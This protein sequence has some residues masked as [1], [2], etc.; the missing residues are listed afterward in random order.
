MSFPMESLFLLDFKL[1][2][3]PANAM[4]CLE[5]EF[6]NNRGNCTPCKQC[7]PGLELSQECGFGSGG[8][9]HCVSCS[10]CF[11]KD[12][13]GHQSC[14]R[15]QSCKL[16]SRLQISNCTAQRNAV[17]GECL[18]GFYSKA[19]IGG[20]QDVQCIPCTGQTPPSELQCS[21]RV[22]IMKVSGSAAPP[23]DTAAAA[24]VCSALVTVAIALMILSFLYCRC[25][26]FG[27]CVQ[28]FLR[29]CSAD[30]SER[31][32]AVATD[33]PRET[34]MQNAA[35]ELSPVVQE[36]VEPIGQ[37]VD[38]NPASLR[39]CMEACT[40][41]GN[42]AKTVEPKPQCVSSLSETQ[43]LI[44]DST[45]STC[46]SWSSSSSRNSAESSLGQPQE[47]TSL[48][49]YCALEQ[50]GR[51][52][53][54]PV[55]CTE[56]DFQ[57]CAARSKE[58]RIGDTAE[59]AQPEALSGDSLMEKEIRISPVNI[60]QTTTSC[61]RVK[62]ETL[63]YGCASACHVPQNCT[64]M[65]FDVQNMVRKSCT[66]TQG[67]HLGRLPPVLVESLSLKLDPSFPGVKNYR[68]LG[69]ELGVPA[70][71]MDSVIGFEHVFSYLSSST[72]TTVP[73]L[74]HAFHRLQRFDALFLLCEYST[75]IHH[76]VCAH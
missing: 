37:P 35:G 62:E 5:N 64:N 60:S 68:Q 30:W 54:V 58:T 47:A 43:P 53:H 20:Q 13:W 11:Y 16:I 22:Q 25:T 75:Q 51:R 76:S 6:Y 34:L 55:E 17:C 74:V 4:D 9:A 46:S 70:E 39:S 32:E 26:S 52:Q 67:L 1:P 33:E 41:P 21:T 3:D 10:P 73:D 40:F 12:E 49:G 65:A 29:S 72:L 63:R 31:G 24:V 38:N 71:L 56:L 36:T 48:N 2:G 8:D 14:K 59:Q 19:R 28:A 66:I 50:E 61:M 45:C 44:R 27:S 18:P 7:P 23:A 57:G 69:L 42:P 15:C